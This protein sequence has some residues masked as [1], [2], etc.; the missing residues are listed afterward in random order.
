MA[1][2]ELSSR[3]INIMFS[4][5]GKGFTS[6]KITLPLPWLKQLGFSE[7]NRKA[8]ITLYDDKIT[9]EICSPQTKLQ[10]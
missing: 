5:N 4:K 3:D 10:T 9:I 2:T 6:T 7:Q 8:K 1:T